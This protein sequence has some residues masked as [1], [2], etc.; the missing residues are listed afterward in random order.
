MDPISLPHCKK[1]LARKKKKKKDLM[2]KYTKQRRHFKSEFNFQEHTDFK[3]AAEEL[4]SAAETGEEAGT[5]LGTRSWLARDGRWQVIGGPSNGS[6]TASGV[7][8]RLC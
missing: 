1:I 8:L 5:P 7:F 2:D 4:I 3:I 6:A